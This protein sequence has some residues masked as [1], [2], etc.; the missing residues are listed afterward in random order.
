MIAQVVFLLVSA[1]VHYGRVDAAGAG[2]AFPV[3][4]ENY[5]TERFGEIN[6]QLVWDETNFLVDLA[7]HYANCNWL[8]KTGEI[9]VDRLTPGGQ[10]ISGVV[11]STEGSRGDIDAVNG[12]I[13]TVIDR[14][15]RSQTYHHQIRGARKFGCSVRPGCSGKAVISCLFS[16][17]SYGHQNEE[18]DNG[19]EPEKLEQTALAFTAEQYLVAERFTGNTWDR[20]HLLENLSGFETSCSMI[21]TNDWPFTKARQLEREYGLRINQEY[22]YTL[23]PGTTDEGLNTILASFKQIR[24]AKSMGCSIIPDCM[25]SGRMY[26]VVAC[27]YED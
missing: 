22:G 16:P 23:H 25:H 2:R 14:W 1:L 4:S 17:G 10:T 15:L 5:V 20:S 11:D 27:F 18:P 19:D 7:G 12:Y 21:G 9:D 13:R 24:T 8:G 26:I 3:D 6:S